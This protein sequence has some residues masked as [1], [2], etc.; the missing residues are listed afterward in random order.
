MRDIRR[1]FT[2]A[3]FRMTAA[4]N[5]NS[6]GSLNCHPEEAQPTKDLLASRDSEIAARAETRIPSLPLEGKVPMVRAGSARS[7]AVTERSGVKPKE[8]DEDGKRSFAE[9]K[10]P[11]PSPLGGEGA[12]RRM[13]GT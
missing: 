8:A 9:F 12:V 3:R 4:G 13:R 1:S 11:K 2:A 7:T 10:F 6:A 5:D